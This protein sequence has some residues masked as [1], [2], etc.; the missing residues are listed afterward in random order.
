[1]VQSWNRVSYFFLMIAI[2]R[3]ELYLPGYFS[4]SHIYTFTYIYT[5]IKKA[6][7]YLKK[8]IHLRQ[9]SVSPLAGFL[10]AACHTSGQSVWCAASGIYFNLHRNLLW[11]YD[12][13]V[14]SGCS[15]QEMSFMNANDTWP[16]PT[17]QLFSL[18]CRRQSISS[19]PALHV[20]FPAL[21]HRFWR[22]S[23]C[24]CGISLGTSNLRSLLG[25]K[26]S[27]PPQIRQC[28]R[29]SAA[30]S[31]FLFATTR[32]MK[33]SGGKG[34]SSQPGFAVPHFRKVWWQWARLL[35]VS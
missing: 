33:A 16:E 5:Y 7:M 4:T 2:A 12:F 1:M 20:S 31:R 19:V 14:L 11:N 35:E 13:S 8:K 6:Y 34:G 22:K 17:T 30:C 29:V 25:Q 26:L 15:W 32:E 21:H 23:R 10:G 24:L 9:C 28:S 3:R 27:P 18:H